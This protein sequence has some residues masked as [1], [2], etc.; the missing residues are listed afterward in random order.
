MFCNS[1]SWCLGLVYNIFLWLIMII[2]TFY[3]VNV[4]ILNERDGMILSSGF[5]LLLKDFYFEA[6]RS[7]D[8]VVALRFIYTHM[9][10]QMYV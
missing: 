3:Q 5:F 10:Y 6:K 1:P 2:H 7:I 8:A 9:C 4:F